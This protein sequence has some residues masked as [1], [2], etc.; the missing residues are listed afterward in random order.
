MLDSSNFGLV[1][2]K[3][4]V[5]QGHRQN[6]PYIQIG[7]KDRKPGRLKFERHSNALKQALHYQDLLDSGQAD[8]QVELARLIDTPRSTIAAYLRL[9]EIDEE[10]RAEA[11]Q[12][13]DEDERVSRLTE[14]RLR[15]LLGM[16]EPTEQR[17]ALRV[18]VDPA[19]AQ[20]S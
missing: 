12:I 5:F 7:R 15:H 9:L 18:L 16:K 8:S 2:D 10:V 17:R 14:A 11:L 3:F 19:W 1:W 6:R 13:P 4:H 20:R